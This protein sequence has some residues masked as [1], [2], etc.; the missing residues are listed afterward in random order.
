MFEFL[1]T[2]DWISVGQT[3]MTILIVLVVITGV[4]AFFEFQFN[5]YLRQTKR[6]R[7]VWREFSQEHGLTFKRGNLLRW[8]ATIRGSYRGHVLLI[9]TRRGRV[10]VTESEAHQS[11]T[12]TKVNLNR[13]E[14]HSLYLN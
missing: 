7:P 6:A 3:L 9:Y 14:I 2:T 4:G 11:S 13:R 5:Q 8:R 1:S 10:E 12:W